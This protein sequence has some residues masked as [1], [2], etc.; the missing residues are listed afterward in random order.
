M[1]RQVPYDNLNATGIHACTASFDDHLVKFLHLFDKV[2]KIVLKYQATVV[3]WTW[4]MTA[5]ALEDTPNIILI[6]KR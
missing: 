6:K 2:S 4:K 3:Q 1:T 5:K